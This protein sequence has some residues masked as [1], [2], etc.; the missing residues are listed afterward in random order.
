MRTDFPTTELYFIFASTYCKMQI[1]QKDEA[2]ARHILRRH[3]AEFFTQGGDSWHEVD[4]RLLLALVA[5]VLPQAIADMIPSPEK[6]AEK[7]KANLG[8]V[9]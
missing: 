5:E 4:T 2:F 6:V 7:A 8:I 1:Y 3:G 9:R